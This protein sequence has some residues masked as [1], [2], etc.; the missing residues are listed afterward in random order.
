MSSPQRPL[1]Q[2][3]G[4]Y[5]PIIPLG[6]SVAPVCS[7]GG[8]TCWGVYNF[9][10]DPN[11]SNERDTTLADVPANLDPGEEVP[12]DNSYH[13]PRGSTGTLWIWADS[14]F[15]LRI[16]LYGHRGLVPGSGLPAANTWP[17]VRAGSLP[18]RY[19]ALQIDQNRRFFRLYSDSGAG[20]V[21]FASVWTGLQQ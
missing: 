11:P 17:Y 14:G 12:P 15:A 8:R 4:F 16:A 7:T 3:R 18:Q 10:T 2:G 13:G 6:G 5:P 19:F 9:A 21:Y 1:G 20:V